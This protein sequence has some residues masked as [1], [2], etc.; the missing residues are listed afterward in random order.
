MCSSGTNICVKTRICCCKCLLASNNSKAL[1][2]IL[3]LITQILSEGEAND[4]ITLPCSKM[5][6]KTVFI[7]L[8]VP[9]F[10]QRYANALKKTTQ[11]LIQRGFRVSNVDLLGKN[12]QFFF[13][14]A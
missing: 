2:Y 12:C 9:D 14:Y 5:P 11:S 3:N 1:E 10:G 8:N 4:L 7:K 13:S 6:T